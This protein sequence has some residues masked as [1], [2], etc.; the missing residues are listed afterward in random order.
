[1]EVF[2]D[3][4]GGGGGSSVPVIEDLDLFLDLFLDEPAVDE[5]PAEPKVLE[6]AFAELPFF[7]MLLVR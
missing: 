6:R 4:D 1:V 2:E 5:Q 3:T 7:F